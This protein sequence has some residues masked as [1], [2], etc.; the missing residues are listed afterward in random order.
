MHNSCKPID[1]GADK[2]LEGA[3]ESGF[4]KPRRTVV[5][6]AEEETGVLK[7]GSGDHAF[8]WK[9]LITTGKKKKKL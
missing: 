8:L 4:C 3:P 6:R 2:L 1:Y 9:W 7:R 5:D